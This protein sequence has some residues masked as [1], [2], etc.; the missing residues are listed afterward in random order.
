MQQELKKSLSAAIAQ[1]NS[2]RSQLLQAAFQSGGQDAV[3]KLEQE[4]DV[5]RDAYFE[6]LQRELDENNHLYKQLTDQAK[7]EAD[8]LT[9]SIKQLNNINDI[10]NLATSVINLVGRILIVL[11]V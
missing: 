11:G 5:L 10:I 1:F 9:K 4:Y 6:I 3:E 7:T 2:K 8:N